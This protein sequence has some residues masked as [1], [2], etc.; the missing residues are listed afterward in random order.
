MLGGGM[1]MFEL[2]VLWLNR[3]R[4]AD[5]LLEPY[6]LYIPP[7]LAMIFWFFTAPDYIFL[8][9]IPTL[10]VTFG[11]RFLCRSTTCRL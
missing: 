4:R 9:T 7:I 11:G 5:R 10:L 6:A 2:N 3:M 1:V 8:G